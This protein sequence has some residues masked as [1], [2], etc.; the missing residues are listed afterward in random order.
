L[1]GE[2]LV[3]GSLLLHIT[4]ATARRYAA[5]N[6]I[7]DILDLQS[8]TNDTVMC[9]GFVKVKVKVSWTNDTAMTDDAGMDG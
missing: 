8:W 9:G 7:C 2:W 1:I 5:P 3:I 6:Y 4:E